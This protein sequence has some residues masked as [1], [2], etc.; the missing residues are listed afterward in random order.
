MKTPEQHLAEY[1]KRYP[2]TPAL[3][4]KVF[5][6]RGK[7]L[8]DWPKWCFIP[9]V[10]WYSI[11]S[12]HLRVNRIPL[13]RMNDVGAL[14]AIGTWRYCQG[15][16]RF[17][18]DIF[19]A[20]CG[21]KITNNLPSDILLR[22]PEWC[23]YVETPGFTW[24]NTSVFGFWAHLE[25]NTDD[26]IGRELRLVFN[27]GDA[28]T[29][30]PVH[31]GDW[32]LLEA[33]QRSFI[34]AEKNAAA[35][36]FGEIIAF[37]DAAFAAKEI[38]PII[39]VLLYIC[40]EEPEIDNEREPGTAPHRVHPEKTKKGIKIFP[41]TKSRVWTVGAKT[42]ALLR[43]AK[44]ASQTDETGRSVRAHI[45]RGHWHGFWLGPRT[46]Q[47]TFKYHWIPPLLVGG[48][49]DEEDE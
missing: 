29:C 27:Y 12:S 28:V 30:F 33:V 44:E 19:P 13:D 14:A 34:E 16:Y 25:H 46:G 37:E 9:L 26:N 3:V 32:S 1:M 8:G 23:I 11:V 5:S 2:E 49:K 17:D 45:R 42:G 43:Q 6:G 22:L 35:N 40:S 39:S 41:P 31:L 24:D 48:Y 7:E 18:E 4:N 36:G 21:S 10:G 15:V 38:E 20:V 47:R